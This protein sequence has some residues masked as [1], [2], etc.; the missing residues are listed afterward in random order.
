LG[1]RVRKTL[2]SHIAA[3]VMA[4]LSVVPALNTPAHAQTSGR[5]SKSPHGNLNQ[6][7]ENCHTATSWKPIRNRPE[8]DHNKTRYPLIGMHADVSCT[9]CHTKLVFSDVG[10]QCANCHADLHKGQFGARCEQCHTVKG[11]QVALQ[12]TREHFNRFPLVGAHA[13]LE[14]DSC[15]KSA[16]VGQFRGLSTDCYSC[17]RQSYQTAVPDHVAGKFSTTCMICHTNM[18]TWLGATFDHLKMTGFALTGAHAHLDCISCHVGGKYQGTPADCAG[19]HLKD[20]NVTNNPNHAQAGFPQSCQTCHSTT[21]WSPATFDHSRF[22]KFPLTGAHS[23][24]ACASCHVGGKFAG[25]PTACYSCHVTDYN[26]TTSPNHLTAKFPQDCSTCHTTVSWGGAT[27]DH[28]TTGFTLTGAHV[29]LTCAN[30]HVNNNYSLTDASCSSCH[31][32]DYN[33]TTSPP[34]RAAGLPLTCQTCH[35]T[36]NWSGATFDHTTTGF[37]LTGAHTSVLCATCHVNNNYSLTDASCAACH[38]P[39]YNATTN[40][41]HKAGGFPLTC[42]TCHS[43]VNWNGATFDHS[44]TGFALTGSHVQVLCGTCHANNNY[45]LTD[46]SCAACHTTDYNG[47]TSPPHKAAAFPLTCQTC[48]STVNWSGATFDHTTTGFALTGAHVSVLCNSCHTNNN[49]ALSDPSCVACHLPDYN[50]TTNPAHKAGGFPTTCLSCH[51]TASWAGATFNHA[52][53]GFALTGSHATLLCGSCHTNNNYSLNDPSCVACHLTDYTGTTNPAHK[54]AGFATTCKTCH[55]TLNWSGATFDHTTTGF[56]LTGA[57]VSVLC[58]SCHTNNNYSLS[59]PSCVACHL[60]DYNGTTNPAHKAGGF[61]TTCLTCHTTASWPGSTFNHTSTGFA[62]TGAHVP[63]L[64]GSC[65][66]NNN[67]SLSDP[68][69]VACHLTDYNGTTNP[70]H[71]AAG[72][73]NTCLTCHTTATWAGATF[74]HSTTP[75]PLTGAHLSVQCITCHV[76]NQFAGTPTGCYSCH[77]ADFKG[78]TNPNHVTAGFPQ[79][80]SVCHST[81]NWNGATFNHSTT[82]F[83]L[84]GA[85]VPLTCNTCHVNNNYALTDPSCAAC[86]TKDYNNTTNPAHA[87]AGFPTTCATCHTTTSWAGATFNHTTTGFALTGAHVNVACNLCH[88]N[89]KFAGTPTDCYSCHKTEYQGTTNPNHVTAAFPTTCQTCHTTT[90]WTGAVFNHTWFPIYSGTHA[91]KWTT[92]ADCHTNSADYSVFACINCHAH[93]KT[94]TDAHHSGVRNYVYNSANCYACHP[95]GNGG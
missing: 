40:P 75:F 57:H 29:A 92:C 52:S 2:A 87:A 13:V 66:M 88:V 31:T 43:T 34:H 53:T 37:A 21:A 60:T 7:C 20:F 86:H 42:Q 28:S 49:Y 55:S 80:C 89:G 64:C 65:H 67:Y 30:C 44:T 93:D 11:W 6:A 61:P 35:S 9:Q 26:K 12:S 72:F 82:G 48:H 39:D 10:T 76:N 54:A 46:A 36:V 45:S 58:S 71:K 50:T 24:V 23:S 95:T 41:A 83:A 38:I 81:A 25:T 16:A 91:G 74:D 90:A 94:S 3:G 85:H 4:V 33:G 22:T 47:T 59:D 14:C 63:L 51:T 70:A 5:V 18:D 62:L 84:T 32:P 73:P 68:S 56:P 27:F 69:C 79:D 1:A 15:H 78:T 17:H 19:C 8:F 77:S